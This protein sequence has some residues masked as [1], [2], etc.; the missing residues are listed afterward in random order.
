M[1]KPAFCICEKKDLDQLRSNCAADQRLCFRYTDTTMPLVPKSKISSLKLFSVAVQPGM[2]RT[3][4]ETQ[5][6]GFLITRLIYLKL[7]PHILQININFMSVHLL[8]S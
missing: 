6:T 3:W 4:S 5:K 2:C 1:R 8:T 7:C